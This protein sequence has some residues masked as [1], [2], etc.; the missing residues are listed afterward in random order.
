[1]S[2]RAVEALKV[3]AQVVAEDTRRSRQLLTHFG[4]GGKV[5]SCID[6]HA[7][8]RDI[9]R[10]VEVLQNGSDVALLTD[11][12]TPS[13]SDPGAALVRRCHQLELKV[14]PIPGPSAVTAAIA[15]S[16][17]VDGPFL[18]VGF[19]PRSG[20][21]RRRWLERIRETTEPVVL[22]ESPHRVSRTIAELVEGQPDRSLCI[23]REL[24]KRFEELATKS[25]AA[26]QDDPRE[27]RGEVTMV[28]GAGHAEE[29]SEA[30]SE[31]ELDELV[32]NELSRG[33]SAREIAAGLHGRAGISK[34]A[35]YQRVLALKPD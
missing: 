29:G 23:A 17:L 22:F 2:P 11:A 32:L 16:G 8:E 26:W 31:Q 4:V 9:A 28:L 6:A 21:K 35:L 24:T 33:S 7:T 18:F 12:G 20:S 15:G 1:M 34:R 10:V 30:L 3:C 13:V 14:V 5:V 19:L 27:F 25:L